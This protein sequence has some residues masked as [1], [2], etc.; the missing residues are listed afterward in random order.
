MNPVDLIGV[1][2]GVFV[3][4]MVL[5]F[6]YKENPL[7]RI[8]EYSF[9]GLA[10]GYGFA[11]AL[12]LFIN[13]ALNPIFL[14]GDLTFIIP[15]VIGALYYAQFTKNYSSLYR[16]PLS[17]AIGYGLGV[18]IWGIF[19]TFFVKQVTATMI[20]IFTGDPLTI[21]DNVILVAGTILSLSY[22]ILYKQQTGVWGGVTKL[23][24]YIILITFGS[25][26]GSTVLGRMATIIQRVQFLVG[27]PAF[28]WSALKMGTPEEGAYAPLAIIAFLA[29]FG[30]F[31]Y[32]DR[33]AKPVAGTPKANRA[34]N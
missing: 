13:Q 34:K 28:P 15:V 22:F 8:A 26:F 2:V 16:I 32:R 12:R 33:K 7:F 9:V 14:A 31:L 27:D 1:W 25:V 23:G 24:K 4:L 30:F 3:T 19:G 18:S 17:L 10:S 5:S 11:A 20:P 29:V 21:L 6:L